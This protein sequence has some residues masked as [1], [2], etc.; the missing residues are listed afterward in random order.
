[1]RALAIDVGSSSLRTALV[2]ERGTLSGVHQRALRVASPHPGEVELDA[3][4]IVVTALEL[5]RRTLQDA[6]GCDCVGITNQRATTVVFDPIS[7]RPVGPA[8]S[9]Q[10]LRTVV[11]CLV[12]QGHG[13]TLAPNQ[14]ATKVKWLLDQS[15]RPARDV[16]FATLET[17]LAWHLS[18]GEVYVSDRSNACLSGLVDTSVTRWDDHTL[19]TVGIAGVGLA[20]LVDTMGPVGA[21]SALPGS[22]WITA[23]VGDQAASLFGQSCGT[24]QA[25]ITFGTGAIL[26]MIHPAS[27]PRSLGRHHSGCY[28]VVMRSHAGAVT[29]GIEG[30]V[31]S[32]GSCVQW[33]ADLGIIGDVAASEELATSVD[34]SGG[35]DFVPAF[36]GLGTPWW[37]FGA[38]GGFF[39][40]TRGSRS[41]HLTRA[42]LEGVAQRGADMIA[43]AEADVGAPLTEVRLDGGMSTNRFF[44]QRLADFSGRVCAVCS[45]REA[46]TRGAGLMALVGMGHLSVEDVE[47]LW[48]PDFLAYPTLDETT[49]E[50][51]RSHWL[52]SVERAAKTI[53]ELSAV[54]F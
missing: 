45:Q 29:W 39:G 13:L 50:S 32:A 34:S 12:L 15:G 46:T 43:A 5:A 36:A 22:P 28:P 27:A 44:V 14:S 18:A 16:R 47:S 42:V 3:A 48:S 9:W 17:W 23:L 7:S 30:I 40:L 10:D 33:L 38:R 31:F 19:E 1:M 37:D 41:E 6:G 51:S 2:D 25:K 26:D 35:V 20:D 53:P 52:K 49:R 21:A 8:L 4:E 11:D 54:S 24:S